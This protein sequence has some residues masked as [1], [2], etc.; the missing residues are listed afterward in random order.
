MLGTPK[1]T[2]P[3]M[4]WQGNFQVRRLLFSVEVVGERLSVRNPNPGHVVPAFLRFQ[5]GIG[6]EGNDKR[7]V[8]DP[9]VVPDRI[10]EW[11][12]DSGHFR[13][14]VFVGGGRLLNA[15]FNVGL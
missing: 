4:R 14:G 11:S 15:C 1:K 2:L 10:D 3:P 13:R 5:A 7:G 8:L 12:R 9:R 6:A